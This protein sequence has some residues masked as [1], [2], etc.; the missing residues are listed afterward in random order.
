MVTGGGF[1]YYTSHGISSA[2]P[3]ASEKQDNGWST[4]WLDYGGGD[5]IEVHAECLKVVNE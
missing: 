1:A 4:T 2:R 3:I 5:V